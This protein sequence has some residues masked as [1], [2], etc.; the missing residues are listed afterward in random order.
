MFQAAL[1]RAGEFGV[2]VLLVFVPPEPCDPSSGANL[3][4]NEAGHRGRLP[5]APPRTVRLACAYS[6]RT[7]TR[8]TP[9]CCRT[10]QT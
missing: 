9:G 5:L 10:K 4:R 1:D 7:T 2:G 8:R 3:S 6:A